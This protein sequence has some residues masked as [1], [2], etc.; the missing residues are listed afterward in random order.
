[1]GL[2]EELLIDRIAKG[3]KIDTGQLLS[4]AEK[5]RRALAIAVELTFCSHYNEVRPHSSLRNRTPKE[6]TEEHLLNS[7]TSTHRLSA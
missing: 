1:M 7:T 5:G 3:F 2:E 6:F 4:E